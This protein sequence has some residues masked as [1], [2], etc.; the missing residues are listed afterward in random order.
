[1]IRRCD[2]I[3]GGLWGLTA[4]NTLLPLDSPSVPGYPS[5]D[6]F[7]QCQLNSTMEQSSPASGYG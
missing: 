7:L 4:S 2:K 6:I 1:M 3:E 5:L